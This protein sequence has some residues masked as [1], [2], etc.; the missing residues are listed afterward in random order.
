R[1]NSLKRDTLK[2]HDTLHIKDTVLNGL[3]SLTK[4]EQGTGFLNLRKRQYLDVHFNNPIFKPLNVTGF[5][6][7]P[8]PKRFGIGPY[9]GY[10][11]NGRKW[12][13]S[14]GISVHYDLIRF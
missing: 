2:I 9:I 5:E 10:G 7:T 8:K 11:F 14:I 4:Y 3:M 12:T 1:L 13:P 6:I